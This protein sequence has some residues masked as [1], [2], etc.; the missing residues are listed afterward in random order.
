MNWLLP[1]YISDAL[2]FEAAQIE[3]RRRALLDLFSVNGYEFVIPP[4]IE[5]LESLLTGTGRDLDLQT[6]KLTDRLSGKTLGIRADIT[7]QVARI[8]AH[9]LNREGVVRLC[10][11]DSALHTLPLAMSANRE[12]LQIGAEI[13]GYPGL[14]ADIEIIRLMAAALAEARLPAG[15]IDIGHIGIFRALIE[16]AGLE[17]EARDELLEALQHKDGPVLA[18]LSANLPKPLGT[19]FREL[20]NLYG[21]IKILDEATRLLPQNPTIETSLAELYSLAETLPDL[22]L[23][24]DLADLRGYHY[25]NGVVFAAY[26][27]A[28]PG[29]IALGG[30]YDGV[31]SVFGRERPATGFSMDLRRVVRLAVSD[32][33][34]KGIIAPCRNGNED[35]QLVET[36]RTL[37]RNGEIVVETLPGGLAVSGPPCDRQLVMREG[38][39]QV[40]ALD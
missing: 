29:A 35:A 5:H 6:F 21:D 13:Y 37:R 9:L 17:T 2:P 16:D 10:Y 20:P 14:A 8:D 27:D 12:P 26:V 38:R 15:R 40:V 33:V 23:S 7:P 22:P 36:I 1:E 32:G 25:H 24:F 4:L 31:G 18:A 28:A 19:V 3:A 30:R 11:C 39:W 34:R